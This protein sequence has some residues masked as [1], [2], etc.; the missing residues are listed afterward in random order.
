M[1]YCLDLCWGCGSASLLP[2]KLRISNK[3]LSRNLRAG[4]AAA[5]VGF[6]W[7]EEQHSSVP[8]CPPYRWSS[9]QQWREQQCCLGRLL[10]FLPGSIG[11]SLQFAI[12]RADRDLV[13]K[14]FSLTPVLIS[15]KW[16]LAATAPSL[17]E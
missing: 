11:D 10:A 7:E 5:L 15:C 2:S 16:W 8:P 1:L 4:A 14:M 17:F 9:L 13:A 12:R 6:C 3:L